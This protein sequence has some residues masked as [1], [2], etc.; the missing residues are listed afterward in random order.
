MTLLPTSIRLVQIPALICAA[1][2]AT[3]CIDVTDPNLDPVTS[4]ASP[5][6]EQVFIRG[7]IVVFEG[8]SS[9]PEDGELSGDALTWFSSIDGDIGTGASFSKSD[10]SLGL[11]SIVLTGQDTDGAE[12]MATVSLTIEVANQ[13]PA[14]TVTS[15]ADGDTFTAGDDI[16]MQGTA[17]DPED[18]DLTGDALVWTSSLAGTLGTGASVTKT[19]LVEG[20]HVITL[21]AT[22]AVGAKGAVSITITVTAPEGYPTVTITSPET[23]TTITAG[24]AVTFVG[25]ATDPEDG[26]LTGDA[27]VWSSSVDG[28]LGTGLSVTKNGLTVGPHVVTLTATDAAGLSVSTSITFTINQSPT[29]NI[30]SPTNGATFT[31]GDAIAFAGTATDDE[32]GTLTGNSLAWSSSADDELGSGTSLSK[33][34]LSAGQHTITLTVTD[35]AGATGSASIVVTIN[36]RPVPSITSPDDGSTF[37]VGDDITMQGSAT[38]P[39]DGDLTG[40]ALAWISSLDGQL[41]TGTSITKNDL[42]N[43]Q[44]TITLTA[45]DAANATRSASIVLTIN[46]PPVVSITSPD[47]GSTFTS[48]DNI[49]MQGAGTDSED[50]DLTGT[51]LVW[52]SSADGQ[53]GT[54]TS[55]SRND[56]S[57]GE[58]TITLTAKD[59]DGATST[60]AVT[61]SV[62]PPEVTVTVTAGSSIG[63]T[64]REVEITLTLDLSQIGLPVSG[65]R[66]TVSWDDDEQ[67]DA[68]KAAFVTGSAGSGAWSSSLASQSLVAK[69]KLQF[70]AISLSG[71]AADDIITLTFKVKPS[72]AGAMVFIPNLTQLDVIDAQTGT[73]TTLQDIGVVFKNINV[74]VKVQE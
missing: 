43:G 7:E 8:S 51:A 18:G 32:D 9:D 29:A 50:G 35:A 68:N 59:S 61:I 73:I 10:L 14:V 21:T 1:A 44:H 64:D 36:A 24:V 49:T 48:G 16:T 74:T 31:F 33:S 60:A 6:N 27:L 56:L 45:T 17:T 3:S 12:G 26:D 23:G 34:D 52:T 22:D 70:A 63:K 37:T 47:D 62:V 57:T 46:Q 30:T 4:I 15:P 54:G 25:S 55:I 5:T 69:G 58:H 53:I 19:N 20:E 28:P 71:I 65:V 67:D 40:D 11:H 38:D 72:D 13:A 41:G 2:A 66:G 42:T 39:E